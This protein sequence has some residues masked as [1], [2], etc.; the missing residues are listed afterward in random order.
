MNKEL[1]DKIIRLMDKYHR[2][3]ETGDYIMT[4]ESQSDILN[5][6]DNQI[7]EIEEP[8]KAIERDYIKNCIKER[9]EKINNR[10]KGIEPTEGECGVIQG[11]KNI[12][13][14]IDGKL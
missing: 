4:S 13:N 10:L 11:Y 7:L 12:I 14:L 5:L 6:F 9:I 3:V 8:I 2:G 1:K